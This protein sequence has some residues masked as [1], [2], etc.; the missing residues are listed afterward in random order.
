VNADDLTPPSPPVNSER[1]T[2]WKNANS[3]RMVLK[4]R[5]LAQAARGS[6]L[7]MA[8]ATDT[9]Q[10]TKLIRA[11]FERGATFF[12]TAKAYGPFRNEQAFRVTVRAL[13]EMI[14]RP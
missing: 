2:T 1:E 5:P 8:L 7:V 13:V 9:A 6:A 3:E 4:S 10:A 11:A 12:D 14:R